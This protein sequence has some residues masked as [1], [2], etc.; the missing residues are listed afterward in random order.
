MSDMLFTNELQSDGLVSDAKCSEIVDHAVFGALLID[1]NHSNPN[2]DPGANNKPRYDRRTMIGS[3]TPDC[4]KRKIRNVMQ[5]LGKP[6]F[7]ACLDH[8]MHDNYKC[9]KA[10]LEEGNADVL[11]K[12]VKSKMNVDDDKE[13]VREM[14]ERYADLRYFGDTM[15]LVK[16]KSLPSIT[17]SVHFETLFSICP[18][19]VDVTYTSRSSNTVTERGRGSETMGRRYYVKHGLY[20][21]YFSV[22]VLHAKKNGLTWGDLEYLKH[23]LCNLFLN[24]ESVARESMEVCRLYWWVHD[25]KHGSVTKHKIKRAFHVKPLVDEPTCFA[26]YEVSVDDL[27]GTTLEMIDLR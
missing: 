1:V 6:V 12:Y 2:G 22:N 16:G 7:N 13:F 9:L 14:C 20:V 18:V 3:M 15:A 21:C 27:P 11:S 8:Q 24:D 23:L 4:I 26:D 5:D 10:R 19:R 17:G 25:M